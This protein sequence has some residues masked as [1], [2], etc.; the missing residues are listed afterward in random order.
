MF[1]IKIDFNCKTVNLCYNNTIGNRTKAKTAFH[2]PAQV[3]LPA[4]LQ[5][6]S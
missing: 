1:D 6:Y 2:S 5:F 4:G 3:L